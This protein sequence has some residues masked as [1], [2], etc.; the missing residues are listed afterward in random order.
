MAAKNVRLLT[1]PT[2][3]GV[4]AIRDLML[5]STV[6]SC[7]HTMHEILMN[8]DVSTSGVFEWIQQL[9]ENSFFRRIMVAAGTFSQKDDGD[10]GKSLCD[11]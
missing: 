3:T 9:S 6:K 5:F 4:R 10:D 8:Y 2:V 7:L 11:R 1:N